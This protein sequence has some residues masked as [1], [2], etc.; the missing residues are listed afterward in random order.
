MEVEHREP[1]GGL[2][3]AVGHRHQRRF[4]QSEDVFDVVLDREGVHQR[5][6]GGAGIAEHHRDALLLEQIEE[7]AFSTHYGQVCL[8]Y[9]L[10]HRPR[11]RTIQ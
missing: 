3:I 11:K 5:Q 6:F 7:G 4:L 1:G 10:C 2:R 9:F 8:P